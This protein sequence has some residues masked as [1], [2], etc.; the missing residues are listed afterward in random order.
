VPSLRWYSIGQ[1][2]NCIFTDNTAEESSVNCLSAC[3][4]NKTEIVNNNNSS[5][6]NIK[7]YII[8]EAI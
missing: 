8:D 3:T 2:S 6:T 5:I 1:Y 4:I 7:S